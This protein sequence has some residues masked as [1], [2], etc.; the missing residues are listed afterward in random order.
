M[1]KSWITLFLIAFAFIVN[2]Q[3]LETVVNYYDI[4]KTKK[5][6]EFTVKKGTFI[7]QG[8]YKKWDERGSLVE[9]YN[10]SNNE[11]HGVSKEY[12]SEGLA[13]LIA[14]ALQHNPE[15]YYRRLYRLAEYNNGIPKYEKIFKYIKDKQVLTKEE[16]YDNQGEL[17]HSKE[18]NIDGIPK[19][20]I[21][22]EPDKTN[23]AYTF[24][25]ENGKPREKQFNF[26]RNNE[27]IQTGKYETFYENGAKEIVGQYKNGFRDGNFKVYFPDGKLK[28][29]IIYKELSEGVIRISTIE[30]F[31]NG[32]TKFKQSLNEDDGFFYSDYYDETTFELSFKS[33][34]PLDYKKGNWTRWYV[35]GNI[36]SD[37]DTDGNYTEYYQDGTIK[38]KGKYDNKEDKKNGDFYYYDSKG[39]LNEIITF[40]MD[41]ED[42]KVS[43]ESI[44]FKEEQE[45]KL[46]EEKAEK[47]R[48]EQE[49]KRLEQE[50]VAEE[51]R[52]RE[53]KYAE[54]KIM[55]K[56]ISDNL[57]QAYS[58]DVI[59]FKNAVVKGGLKQSGG[60]GSKSFSSIFDIVLLDDLHDVQADNNL[61]L[62]RFY[63]MNA[64]SL[65]NSME[66]GKFKGS[67][68]KTIKLHEE[69]RNV[70]D[71]EKMQNWLIASENLLKISNNVK[72]A[73]EKKDRKTIREVEKE[74]STLKQYVD[75]LNTLLKMY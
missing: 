35:N 63:Y 21:I 7:K 8:N 18:Y 17:I 6:E 75:G 70:N 9:D 43:G 66:L 53:E 51:K 50:K 10:F 58:N 1:K 12:Y 44:R 25:Y 68:F 2:A 15:F 31:D 42:R 71:Y 56:K 47:E 30:Y 46:A 20:I 33:K 41:K 60:L 52:I 74:F 11:L 3:Q 55:H 48:L 5:L 73:F 16:L 57:T 38:I 45:K 19:I 22:R 40:K 13:A 37:R 54:M 36:L 26:V 24:Y 4:F 67:A 32:K 23:Y 14:G 28:G 62:F 39:V 34:Q 69:P 29:E 61:T 65:L 49:K 59:I 27:L 64:V 72:Q